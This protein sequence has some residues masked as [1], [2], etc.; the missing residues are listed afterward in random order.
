[1]VTYNT[2]IQRIQIGEFDNFHYSSTPG[3]AFISAQI[4]NAFDMSQG[5]FPAGNADLTWNIASYAPTDTNGNIIKLKS[6]TYDGTPIG[7]I[8]QTLLTFT[9]PWKAEIGSGGTIYTY[10]QHTFPLRVTKG[11]EHS[12]PDPEIIGRLK[13]ESIDH[14]N[15]YWSIMPPTSGQVSCARNGTIGSASGRLCDWTLMD[16]TFFAIQTATGADVN[17]FYNTYVLTDTGSTH[18]STYIFST[19]DDKEVLYPSQ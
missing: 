15:T 9:A 19:I 11:G 12:L 13:I 2:P 10:M 17:A 5:N 8:P 4:L 1:V 16:G 3:D 7:G 18:A 6:I 14:L